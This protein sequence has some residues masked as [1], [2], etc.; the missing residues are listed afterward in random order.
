M[1]KRDDA[2]VCLRSEIEREAVA[3]IDSMPPE[4]GPE[5]PV[6]WEGRCRKAPPYPDCPQG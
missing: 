6:V 1:T 3:L 4:Y 2:A 5:C